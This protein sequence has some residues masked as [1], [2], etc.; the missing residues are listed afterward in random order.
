LIA[1]F[2]IIGAGEVRRGREFL[3][4][5]QAGQGDQVADDEKPNKDASRDRGRTAIR[6]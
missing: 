2:R 1:T 5:D 3:L 4:H 6:S